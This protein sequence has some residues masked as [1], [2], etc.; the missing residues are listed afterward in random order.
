[1]LTLRPLVF[2][3]FWCFQAFSWWPELMTEHAETFLSLYRADMDAALQAQPADSW[4]SFPL[5]QLLNNFLRSD[6]ERRRRL[7]RVFASTK[8]GVKPRRSPAHFEA[9]PFGHKALRV[10]E[11]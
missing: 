10:S 4:N 7:S 3:F 11:R 9:S 6:G 5:F 8:A 2:F 1:M